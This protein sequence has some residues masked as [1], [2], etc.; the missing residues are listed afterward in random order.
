MN[1]YF[2]DAS[3]I[4]KYYVD[5]P[6]SAWVRRIIASRDPGKQTPANIGFIAEVSIAEAA[7]A[8][9]ILY[10]TE[11]LS[12]RARD[13]IFAKFLGEANTVFHLIPVISEDFYVAAHL[14]Q[15]HPLKA[16]DA[17]HLAVA[18]RHHHALARYE[19]DLIFVSG[20]R[21]Q[22]EAAAAEGLATDNPFDHLTPSDS[23]IV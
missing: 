17:V 22:L 23:P 9:S 15:H 3:A 19:R 11:R 1:Y 16:Y 7:A 12:R 5:E 13:G 14:T 10:R 6:G 8:Y 18:L 2:F 21:Q 20:D 4:V